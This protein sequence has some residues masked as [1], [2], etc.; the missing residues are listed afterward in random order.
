MFLLISVLRTT[1]R[2]WNWHFWEVRHD[3]NTSYKT[4]LSRKPHFSQLMFWGKSCWGE[5]TTFWTVKQINLLLLWVRMVSLLFCFLA[6]TELKYWNV[7]DCIISLLLTWLWIQQS[8]SLLFP[9]WA[10]DSLSPQHQF[11]PQGQFTFKILFKAWND[12]THL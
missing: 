7:S 12:S 6:C 8:R 3:L 11:Q 1:E 9:W 5:N 10:T 2:Y 4:V